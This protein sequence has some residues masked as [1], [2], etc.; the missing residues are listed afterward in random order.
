MTALWNRAWLIALAGMALSACADMHPQ[1][2]TDQESQAAAPAPAPTPAPAPQPPASQEEGAPSA[3]P[4]PPVSAEALP[5]VNRAPAPEAAPV[6]AAPLPPP[7]PAA[8]PTP[9]YT[10]PPATPRRARPEPTFTETVKGEV[11][12]AS[13]K[14]RVVYV[15]N[16]DT[17]NL[18]AQRFLTSQEE[19]IKLNHLKKPYEIDPGQPLKTPTPKVYVVESGDTLYSIGRRFNVSADVLAE[20]NNIEAKGRLRSGQEIALPPGMHDSGPLKHLEPG[21]APA[22]A[23][24][25]RPRSTYAPPGESYS[26]PSQPQPY[27]HPAPPV[28]SETPPSSLPQAEAA[29]ALSDD[30]IT[31]AG[32]GRFVWPAHGAI[33]SP[34]G[35]KP[36]GQANDGIN[37]G[38]P[39][40]TTVQAAAAGDVVYAGNQVPGY[41][42]LVLIK[43]ADGWVTAYAYLSRTSV[44]IKD[45]LE[46]GDAVGEVGQ[47]GG[48]DTPQLHFEIRYA[49][50]PHDKAKPI[51][52]TLVLPGN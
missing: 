3:T 50:T 27:S 30:Q 37:I 35:P 11:R 44:K 2:P 34:F 19:I 18:L 47:T 16:G 42:N 21:S 36:G 31:A 26:P 22:Y 40:G 8:P 33:L 12:E 51:N 39:L 41:G 5:P 49:P 14:S 15:D 20:L 6:Q 10:P 29:P 48:V 23:P 24:P 4:A 1:Y 25:E 52:P 28:R 13:E 46:Q 17:V 45:H 32:R 7:Q 9:A 38:A 43:H